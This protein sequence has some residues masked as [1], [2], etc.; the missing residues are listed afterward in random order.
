MH[1]R[2]IDDSLS[3]VR[4]AA[5]WVDAVTIAAGLAD[6]VR[7]DLQVCLEEALANLIMHG[8]TRSSAKDMVV[9]I[10]ASPDA[11]TLTISD[12]CTP[13]DVTEN[14]SASTGGQPR[15]GGYGLKLMR[16][17]ASE[18]TYRSE[19]DR[20]ELRMTF[21][22]PDATDDVA[23]LRLIPLF[24][25]MP[26]TALLQLARG[27]QRAK[28]SQGAP[29]VT[30]GD[31]SEFALILLS[32]EVAIVNESQHGDAPLAQIAAPALIG[33]IGALANLPRTASV[34]AVTDVRVLLIARAALLEAGKQFPD[35]FVSVIGQL[36]GQIRGI[37]KVLGLYAAGLGALERDDFDPSILEELNN[38]TPDARNF[39]AAF[40]RLAQR[41]TH[42]RRTRAEL[43]SAALIQRAMLP[44]PLDA[45]ALAGRCDA[46]GDMKAAREVSGDLFDLFLIDDRRL[47]LVVGDVCGKGVPAA[48]F[49]CATVTALRLVAQ[50]QPR[51]LGALI[52]Q[53]N[54]VLCAQN[55]MSMFATL[56]YGVLDLDERRL[57][58]VNCGHNPPLLLAPDGASSDL[59]GHGPPLGLFP[60]RDWS[61][62]TR[63][64]EPGEG[65]VLFTDGVTE[66]VD[67][68]GQEYGDARLAELLRRNRGCS[69]FELV[70]AVIAD[71]ERFAGG[72]EQFDDL[73]CLVALAP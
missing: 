46:F 45:A 60:G 27:S 69:A 8:K 73:T 23:L 38:P 16:A 11:A 62:N 65:I 5:E 19:C 29:V 24:A 36:G 61:V 56:F 40:Q 37:N 14:A 53:A 22:A 34:R 20:N 21:R 59:P 12:R 6:D 49:M 68:A 47:A 2:E 4:P 54:D 17:L 15:V 33:E 26:Q 55:A 3:A 63:V 25:G 9:E 52:R 28:F 67:P 35:L 13:F 48:L 42:E 30:Q 43:A 7:N 66:N 1:R 32:G 44:P 71:A 51:D 50:Q 72:G 10:E 39:T 18:L 58:Y 64:L 31:A 41:V 57:D 70:R